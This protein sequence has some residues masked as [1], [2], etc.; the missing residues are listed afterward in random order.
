MDRWLHPGFP[1]HLPT[2]VDLQAGIRRI[3]TRHRAQEVLLNCSFVLLCDC[4]LCWWSTT[5][6]TWLI[7]PIVWRYPPEGL[8][9]LWIVVS[10]LC[11]W[12]KG[13]SENWLSSLTIQLISLLL[14][15]FSSTCLIFF[16]LPTLFR[17]TDW[18]TWYEVRMPVVV[19]YDKTHSWTHAGAHA[20]SYNKCDISLN[21]SSSV[22]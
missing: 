5:A 1:L 8:S 11:R 18:H 17:G 2:D 13:T 10:L 20:P 4:T 6:V 15:L 14:Y 19:S 22:V 3:W 16:I 12:L 9:S 7:T 21:L